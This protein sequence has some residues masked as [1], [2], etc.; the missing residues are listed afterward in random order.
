MANR[1]II[2]CFLLL[3]AL[4]AS[5]HSKE[6]VDLIVYGASV[7]T[8]DSSFSIHEAFAVKDGKFVSTG[9]EKEIREKF[10]AENSIDAQGKAIYPGFYDAH[11]HFFSFARSLRQVDLVDVVSEYELVERVKKFRE[12]YPNDAWILGRGWD[13][14]KWPSKRF[15]TNEKLNALFPDVPVYLRR[16]DGHAALANERALTL[17]GV[18]T[19]TKIT[20]GLI[21]KDSQGKATGVLVDN[22]MDLVAHNIPE[23]SEQEMTDMLL[24]AQ[25]ACFQVGLTTLA[26][27]GLGTSQID[28]LRK[29]YNNETLAIREYAMIALD[30]GTLDEVLKKGIE[31]NDHLDVRAFKIVG[32]GALG[33]RGA[34]LLEPYLDDHSTGFLLHAPEQLDSIVAKVARSK[35]QLN[36]HAIGDSANRVMLDLYNKYLPEGNDRRW[37]IEHAQVLSPS[38]FGKFIGKGI[39]P[40]IQPT[41]A[42]S[43]MFWAIDRLGEER[44][45]GAYAY[46]KL[47][48][49]AGT[50]AF[51]SDF[52]VEDINPLYGLH[53]AVARVD[54]ANKPEGGFQ[55]EN[56]LSREEALRG[57][58]IW[59]AR[60]CFQEDTRGSIEK[61]K[62]ADFVLLEEDIMKAPLEALRQVKVQQTFVNGKEVFDLKQ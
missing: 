16:I 17:A 36:T 32:D 19:N 51:G 21:V 24:E 58:T 1:L 39:I 15:P 31:T 18:N 62:F 61:G 60:A 3:C 44:L 20:G 53:A 34:C 48:Q 49:E 30:P 54:R 27:A 43:D 11:C 7:Y 42:T 57:M 29:L 35:F 23:P 8:V 56:A 26:D 4:L 10:E 50:V 47:L 52:P 5:C 9:S 59:A 12:Q 46:K 13:Q 55:M 45:E 2:P 6:K 40:S 33:S 25:K 41:H 28:L 14:N 38:D 37:R 22:A